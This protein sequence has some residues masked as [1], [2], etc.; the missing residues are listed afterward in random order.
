[1]SEYRCLVSSY[2][3]K[4]VVITRTEG[5][6]VEGLAGVNNDSGSECSL[7]AKVSRCSIPNTKIS[8][9]LPKQNANARFL[10]KPYA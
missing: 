7:E 2:L 9:S 3:A 4:V 10:D 6:G 8:A 5:D 1:M